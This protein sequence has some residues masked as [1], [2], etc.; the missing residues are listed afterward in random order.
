MLA[1]L[2]DYGFI[3]D[4]SFEPALTGYGF[5]D[6]ADHI[7]STIGP[8]FADMALAAAER[9]VPSSDPAPIAVMPVWPFEPEGGNGDVLLSSA[10]LWNVGLLVEALRVEGD[11]DPTPVLSV[12]DRFRRW[13]EAAGQGEKLKPTRLHGRHGCYVLFAAAA[14]A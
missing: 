5:A 9:S 7:R 1:A 2:R 13:A 11:D 6:L 12:R 8:P 4:A 10:R 3:L 14:P